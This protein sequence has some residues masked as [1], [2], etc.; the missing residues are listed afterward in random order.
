MAP[1]AYLPGIVFV[2]AKRTP[3]GTYLGA[4]KGVTATDLGVHASKA[5][6]EESGVSPTQ[7]DQVIFGQV[8]AASARDGIYGTRHI[9]LKAGAPK[10]TPALT[11]NRL[12]GSGFQAVVSGAEQ[13]A[14]G[15]ANCVLVGGTENMSQSPFMIRGARE[16]IPLGKGV[17][18]DSLWDAL[19]DSYIKMPMGITAENLATEYKITQKEVDEF[20]YRSQQLAHKA[21]QSGVLKHEIAPMTL[22]VNKKPR[23]F[24]A[25]EHIREKSTVEGY[26]KLPKVFKPDGVIHAGSA[27]GICD[28]AAA[29]IMTTEKFA[30]AN[31][32]KVIGR[33]LS[34]GFAG[35]EPK[36]MGIGPV[37]ASRIALD[38]AGATIEDMDMVEIN[39]AFAPQA[40]ACQKELKVPTEKL[41]I[42]GGAIAIG[43]PLGASGARITVH[44][45]HALRLQGKK[46]GLGS[47]CI[48]GG[49]GISVIVESVQ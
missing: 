23:V 46:Y 30:T 32:L 21:T 28:G 16:G 15:Q 6:F 5:C 17:L 34:Y 1:K 41:N 38:R 47:A 33:L 39:E 37:P 26:A 29:M 20:S 36:I 7:I 11:V 13:L 43:H 48:G 12:C 14:L 22:T 49:Q 24:E 35:C 45:L 19:T 8:I 27:S 4:L 31:K 40:L 25:D 44:L 3:F 2:A 42:H 18:E 9:G 10:Q